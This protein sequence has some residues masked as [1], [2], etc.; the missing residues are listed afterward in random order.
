MVLLYTGLVIASIHF[1]SCLFLL[2]GAIR[3]LPHF[4]LPWTSTV[5]FS[6]GS[7]CLFLFMLAFLPTKECKIETYASGVCLL[8]LELYAWLV[9]FSYYRELKSWNM[10][11]T[12]STGHR[13]YNQN[14]GVFSQV[15]Q[16]VSNFD[17]NIIW[18][19]FD[20]M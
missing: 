13:Y 14:L 15:K 17:K 20:N 18:I 5:V 2:Y 16:D 11:Y 4:L 9:V 7:G 3:N 10:L 12:E 1:I 8:G 6:I 19:C